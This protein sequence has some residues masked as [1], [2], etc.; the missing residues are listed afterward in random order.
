MNEDLSNVMNQFS[1]ILK[2]K[3]IDIN[4]ILNKFSDNPSNSSSN[5]NTNTSDNQNSF[6]SNITGE[7][8]FNLDIET[9]L[10][11]KNIMQQM[12]Q[13]NVPRNNL[14]NS[15]KPF[16]RKEK[17]EKL[18]EYIKYANLLNLLELFNSKGGD[19]SNENKSINW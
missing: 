3:N 9:I 5:S 6:T 15:L 19:N 10:K 13:K 12:N 8:D 14:L 4:Q 18:D 17:Q 11:I 7:S 16:L 2:E 1:N